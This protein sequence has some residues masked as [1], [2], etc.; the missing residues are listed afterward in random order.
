MN[1]NDEIKELEE[2]IK[3]LRR[4]EAMPVKS[5]KEV[6]RRMVKVYK[7]YGAE[8]I[9]HYAAECIETLKVERWALMRRNFKWTDENV[10]RLEVVNE[11]LKAALLDMRRKT[12]EV[13]ESLNSWRTPD[14][15]LDVSG[16]L[17]VESMIFEGWE[18]DTEIQDLLWDI[19]TYPPYCGG[20]YEYNG[21][22]HPYN[23]DY[24]ST[25]SHNSDGYR[26]ENDMLYLSDAPDNWNELMNRERTD[27]L[28]LVYGI[29]NLY[30]HCHWSLQDLLGIR[31]YKIKIEI[32]QRNN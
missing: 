4:L 10:A 18:T 13:Y 2:K 6:E 3:E 31:S 5:I 7:E 19:M 29:H 23:L 30:E 12:I 16:T 27:H 21:I 11:Q 9:S 32:E 25:Y 1:V 15:I 28:H 8:D 26:T 14:K 17:W 22:S 24:D 20:L